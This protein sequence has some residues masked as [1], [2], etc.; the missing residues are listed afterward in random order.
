MASSAASEAGGVVARSKKRK[1]T[2][3]RRRDSKVPPSVSLE[4]LN[5]AQPLGEMREEKGRKETT[6][7]SQ[8]V[9]STPVSNITMDFERSGMEI[10]ESDSNHSVVKRLPSD[11]GV[12]PPSPSKITLSTTCSVPL[13]VIEEPAE[14]GMEEESSSRDGADRGRRQEDGDTNDKQRRRRL[15]RSPSPALIL[16]PPSPIRGSPETRSFTKLITTYHE[17]DKN[18]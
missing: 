2:S 15:C 14:D 1:M 6:S 17:E 16:P 4:G 9:P 18:S 5:I 10:L 13:A 8:S 11:P 7:G 3:N 12:V